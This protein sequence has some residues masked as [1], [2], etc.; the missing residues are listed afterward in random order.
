MSCSSA[1]YTSEIQKIT[2]NKNE[3]KKDTVFVVGYSKKKIG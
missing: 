1:R 3:I 2:M